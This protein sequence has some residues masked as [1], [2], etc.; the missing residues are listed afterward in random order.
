M[1]KLCIFD[2][3][4]TVLDT[5]DTIS[6]Y[7]NSALLKNGLTEIPKERYKYLVG[8]G[9]KNL[10]GAM[11]SEINAPETLFSKVFNDYNDAYNKNTTYKTKVYEG[12]GELLKTL[13]EKGISLAI[14]SNKPDFATKSVVREILGD[15]LFDAVYGQRE[16]VPIKPD[17]T[18]VYSI[19]EEFN[20]EKNECLYIGDT[21]VDILTAKNA[22]IFSVGVLWGFR[23]RAELKDARADRII[24]KPHEILK[25][26]SKFE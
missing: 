2:L 9:A 4:G 20:V 8:K 18:S 5:L 7:A 24:S 25:I 10:V 14:L 26:I 12:M 3:D 17:P 22:N 1:I 16:G 13:K 23:T 19:L 11:L 6:Y 21:S 15:G